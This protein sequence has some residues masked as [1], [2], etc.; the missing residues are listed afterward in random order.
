MHVIII[1]HSSRRSMIAKLRL[2]METL[3]NRTVSYMNNNIVKVPNS[4]MNICVV[5]DWDTTCNYPSQ[6]HYAHQIVFKNIEMHNMHNMHNA[7]HVLLLSLFKFIPINIHTIF[8]SPCF[9]LIKY[10]LILSK[11][12]WVTSM[13][14]GKTYGWSR[15]NHPTLNT[16]R[17]WENSCHIPDIFKCIF[18]NENV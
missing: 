7:T 10:R 14:P 3:Y 18:L 5:T 13:A 15:T 4:T 16:L 12:S 2:P 17:P 1:G 9:A 6:M 8:D 11:T